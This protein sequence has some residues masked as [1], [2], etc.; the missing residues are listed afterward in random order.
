MAILLTSLIEYIIVTRKQL[1]ISSIC[2]PI[3]KYIFAGRL[4]ALSEL[5]ILNVK[6]SFTPDQIMFTLDSSAA[7]IN[8]HQLVPK[9]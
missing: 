6:F 9:S 1:V 2:L 7:Q 8:L 3:Q 5:E 4:S